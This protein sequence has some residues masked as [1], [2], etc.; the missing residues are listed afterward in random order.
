MESLIAH[1]IAS[2]DSVLWDASE[3]EC[4]RELESAETAYFAANCI[5]DDLEMLMH[6]ILQ[7]AA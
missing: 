2:L 7:E 6:E 1:D 3:Y 4:Y 5:A